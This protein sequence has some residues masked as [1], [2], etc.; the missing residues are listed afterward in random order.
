MAYLMRG[1]KR[2][3]HLAGVRDGGAIPC[4]NASSLLRADDLCGFS[5]VPTWPTGRYRPRFYRGK[6]SFVKAA[7]RLL[8]PR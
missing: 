7:V 3:L 2:R 5:K 8:F 1:L 4:S 6:I